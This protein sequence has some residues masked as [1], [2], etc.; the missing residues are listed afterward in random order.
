MGFAKET[1]ILFVYNFISHNLISWESYG[2]QYL[3]IKGRG[4]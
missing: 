3:E 2:Y 1:Y 4:K